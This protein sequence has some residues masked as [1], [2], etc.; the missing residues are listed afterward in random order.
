LGL[1][2][3]KLLKVRVTF[4]MDKVLVSYCD[5][6]HIWPYID[7]EFNS[8]FPIR[9]VEWKTLKKERIVL[10]V[11][12][13]QLESISSQENKGKVM[14]HVLLKSN[15]FL[16]LYFV[17]C[18]ESSYKQTAKKQIKSWLETVGGKKFQEWLIVLVVGGSDTKE[19]PTKKSGFE[20]K[21]SLFE[22]IKGDFNTKK[23]RC[24]L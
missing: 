13:I 4:I 17:V 20:I 11:V 6:F 18:D 1:V 9:N 15:P 7:T 5:E 2:I 21:K 8:R 16:H 19:E 23:D 14:R 22:K 3:G 12:D 10:P 24:I